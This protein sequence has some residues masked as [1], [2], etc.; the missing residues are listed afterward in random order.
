MGLLGDGRNGSV[1]D[2]TAFLD[3]G[4]TERVGRIL[5]MG[6]L[7]AIG[8]TRDRGAVSIQVTCDGDWD[9]EYFRRSDEATDW[10]DAIIK[11]AEAKGLAV[12]RTDPPSR[13]TRRTGRQKLT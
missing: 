9:R 4:I 12:A 2:A 11:A 8:T 7:L 10:L 5:D 6:L 3:S 1:I 13:Q